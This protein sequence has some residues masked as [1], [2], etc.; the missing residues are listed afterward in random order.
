VTPPIATLPPDT[1]TPTMPTKPGLPGGVTPPIATLPPDTLTPTMP[2]K[3]GLPG[4]VT[5]PIATLPPDTLTPTMPTKPGLPGGVTPPIA[6]LP[7][8]PLTPTQPSKPALPGGVQPPIAVL[9][10]TPTTGPDKSPLAA[11]GAVVAAAPILAQPCR[12]QRPERMDQAGQMSDCDS[13]LQAEEGE[14][15]LTAGRELV[16]K[17]NWNVWVDGSAS[18]LRDTRDGM[19]ARGHTGA[20]SMGMDRVVSDDLVAGVQMFVLRT[21]SKSFG[22]TLQ[23]EAVSYSV[24][25]Y[26]SYSL[27]RNWLLYGAIGLGRQTVDTQIVSLNSKSSSNQYSLNLQ[28]EGQYA[29]GSALA[30]PRLQL[31]QTYT[32]GDTYQLKGSILNTPLLIDMRKEAFNYGVVQG[33]VELNRTFD[34]G[35]GRLVMPFIE[36]GVYYEYTRPD[37]GRHLT[38]DLTYTSS[39]PWGGILRGGARSLLGKSTM[40]S[41]DIANQTVGVNNLSIW[42]LRLLVSHAF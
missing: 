23:A 20:L 1:L 27:S 16:E 30:R 18:R 24:G 37:S 2:T 42:E 6:T 32:E 14:L 35:N 29:I 7:P 3:P 17:S 40:A 21:D 13:E 38:G 11:S 36:A 12:G 9:P 10:E 19:D 26:V 5:P 22:D 8:D 34:L 39:S 41:L 28:A 33:S 31:S 15:P 25:P 4:G